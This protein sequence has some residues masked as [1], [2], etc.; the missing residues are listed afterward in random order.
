VLRRFVRSFGVHWQA[1]ARGRTV[2]L[3]RFIAHDSGAQLGVRALSRGL[4]EELR[5]T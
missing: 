4:L 5:S 3:S 2:L 1:L